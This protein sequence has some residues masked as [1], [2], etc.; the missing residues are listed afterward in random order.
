[1][2]QTFFVDSF[3]QERTAL[4][5]VT[6]VV[7]AK[8]IRLRLADSREAFARGAVMVV[9]VT[10]GSGVR[11]KILE[12]WARGLPVV[13]T[14]AAAA[15]LDAEDGRELLL[16]RNAPDFVLALQRLSRD[17]GLA[18]SVVA[19]GREL[20]AARHDPARV[21]S[22]LSVVYETACRPRPTP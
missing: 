17:P 7:D 9:P 3:L 1:V 22:R 6:T 16:V 21:A 4:D 15:G 10:F 19:A 14:P 8:H 5:S 18:T 11:M 20:L 13:A 12:A 2:A